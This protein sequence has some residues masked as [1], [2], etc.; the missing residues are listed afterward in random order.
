MASVTWGAGWPACN[1]ANIVT[2]VR[3]DG[4]RIPLHRE[5]VDLVSLLMDI[6]ETMG[7]NIVPSWTWGYACR[8]IRG[9]QRPSNHSWGT[10]VDINA[11][12]NPMS[13]TLITD[14]PPAVRKIWKDHGFRWGGD[15]S[16]RKDAMHFEFMGSVSEAKATLKSLRSYL[17]AN[18]NPAP[19]PPKPL[20]TPVGRTQEL[21]R[22]LR[23]P[24]DGK[25]G[26][27]TEA[28]MN[29]NM[30]GWRHDVAGNK[31]PNLVRWLQRQG[32]RKGYA[33]NVDGVVG[34]EVN[35]LIVVVLGQSDGLCGPNGYRAA[36]T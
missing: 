35:H 21:Q 27:T 8:P 12:R 5:L 2:L 31:N 18:G 15:Y 33:L 3:K 24:D 28:A 9:V 25:I 26:P 32:R 23:V 11:P 20:P 13:S 19:P 14:I 7:Y 6:T 17:T 34:Q 29:R 30:I 1:R 16:G 22:L 36:L 4:L 10:A